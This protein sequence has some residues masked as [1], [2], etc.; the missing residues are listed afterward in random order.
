M[1]PFV[2][3]HHLNQDGMGVEVGWEGR[4]RGREGATERARLVKVS[5]SGVRAVGDR[6]MTFFPGHSAS[7]PKFPPLGQAWDSFI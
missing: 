2:E 3:A 6:T 1:V 5:L 7:S 4:E